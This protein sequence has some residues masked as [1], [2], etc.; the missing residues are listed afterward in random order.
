MHTKLHPQHILLGITPDSP[1][2]GRKKVIAAF[3]GIAITTSVMLAQ[4]IHLIKYR[5]RALISQL[6]GKSK[7]SPRFRSLFE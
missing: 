6:T 7:S 2:Q 5:T 3:I 1:A 4:D